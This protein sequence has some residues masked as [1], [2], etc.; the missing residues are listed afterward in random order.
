ME[1]TFRHVAEAKN[2]EFLDHVDRD[3]ARRSSPTASACSRSSRTCCPT[4][5]NSRMTARCRLTIEPADS[6]WSDGPRGTEQGAEV[7][8]FAVADSGIGIS[9]DKQQII[10][11]AFQQADGSTSRKYGG[12]GLGL[13][14]SREL[15]RLLGGEIRLQSRAG[16][17]Q[18]LH[19]LSADGAERGAAD[20]R[21]SRCHRCRAAQRRHGR[22]C[23]CTP[24]SRSSAGRHPDRCPGRPRHHRGRRPCAADRRERSWLCQCPARDRARPRLQGPRRRGGL[25]GAVADRDSTR[26]RSRS[27]SYLPD[28]E[29]W[30]VL[31]RSRTTSPTAMCRCASSRPTSRAK[32]HWNRGAYSFVAKPIRSRDLVEQVLDDA[33]HYF[34]TAPKKELLIATT[35]A[36][37]ARSVAYLN[38]EDVVD[39]RGEQRRRAAS[40]GAGSIAASCS[41]FDAARASGEIARALSSRPRTAASAVVVREG[42]GATV[43]DLD[44]LRRTSVR[45]GQSPERLHDQTALVLHR[46]VCRAARGAAAALLAICTTSTSRSQ[47]RRC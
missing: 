41:M 39:R 4:P 10:F 14:I 22:G 18:H 7:V 36:R 19:A 40:S 25:G 33:H 29:G 43:D 2:V 34:A 3:A 46:N 1:R 42:R 24:I 32:A 45:G 8:A 30:Q 12:T 17:R 13:A 27:T 38:G 31:D 28:M 6:G 37:S 47:A 15:S 21:P 16:R 11:E 23:R 44:E 35:I 26:R 5:S 20:A 9:P